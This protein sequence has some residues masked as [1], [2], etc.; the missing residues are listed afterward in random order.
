MSGS[1]KPK[2]HTFAVELYHSLFHIL[3]IK[4]SYRINRALGIFF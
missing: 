3:M 2:V 1:G 4:S